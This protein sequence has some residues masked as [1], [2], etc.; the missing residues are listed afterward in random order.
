MRIYVETCVPAIK[1]LN[2]AIKLLQD[3]KE[4]FSSV[5]QVRRSRAIRCR[6]PPSGSLTAEAV[7]FSDLCT[8]DSAVRRGD[9]SDH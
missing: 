7:T 6:L 9:L 3:S 5:W 2:P 4:L 8:H 1:L